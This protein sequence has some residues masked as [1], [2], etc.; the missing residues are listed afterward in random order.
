MRGI[1]R[2]PPQELEHVKAPC[3]RP[4]GAPLPAFD[5]PLTAASRRLREAARLARGSPIRSKNAQEASK[6]RKEKR[7]K[8]HEMDRQSIA[9]S[10]GG[11][12]VGLA[13]VA[14]HCGVSLWTVR[15]WVATG[16]LPVVK[17]SAR[18]FR[19]R[20]ADLARFLEGRR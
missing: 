12:L 19:T 2:V 3:L 16:K 20:P 15:D 10:L 9:D 8:R 6:D 13:A 11:R 14:E 4:D 1:S 18:A 17:L 7:K 5:L